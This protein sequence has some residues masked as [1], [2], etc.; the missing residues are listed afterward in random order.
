MEIDLFHLLKASNAPLILFDR[1]IDW[2]RR[3]ESTLDH[4]GSSSLTKR[5]MLLQDLNQKLYHNE[6]LMKPRV[7]NIRLSSGRTTNVVTFSVK[8]MILRMVMNKSL[9]CPSNILL[10]PD[11]PCPPPS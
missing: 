4:N 6:I 11:N 3:H 2:V 9:F 1:I 8:E 7:H 5:K 10:D